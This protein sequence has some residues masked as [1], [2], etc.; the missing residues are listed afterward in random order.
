MG[1][2]TTAQYLE[3]QRRVE[4]GLSVR[5]PACKAASREVG[6]GGLHEQFEAWLRSL[7][8]RCYWVSSRTDKRSTTRV[9]V[10]DFVGWYD[11][12]PWAVELK[13]KGRKASTEQLG[14]LRWAELAGARVTVAYSMDE[15][16]TAV[17]GSGI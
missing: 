7:G 16:K 14:E 12:H 10:S 8:Q 9:G 3:M 17:I 2:I 11:G 5:L 6:D 13:A 15:A 4:A 1:I